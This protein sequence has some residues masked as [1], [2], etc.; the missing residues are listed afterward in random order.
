MTPPKRPK[1]PKNLLLDPEAVARGERYSRRHGT[2]LSRLVGDF[3]RALPLGA[4][5]SELAPSVKRLWGVARGDSRGRE[6]Y[7]QHLS[8]KYGNR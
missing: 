1:R 7:R 5:P 3:L 4:D 2:T 8:R 6:L